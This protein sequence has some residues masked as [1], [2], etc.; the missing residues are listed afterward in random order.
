MMSWGTRH[1]EVMSDV[2]RDEAI[3]VPESAQGLRHLS[4]A[5][6]C[7][8]SDPAPAKGDECVFYVIEAEV[9]GQP[10]PMAGPQIAQLVG[11]VFVPLHRAIAEVLR[12]AAGE[13][14]LP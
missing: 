2:I 11:A 1:L 3:A 8:G 14:F 4:K 9:A 6:N 12:P 13:E 10:R 5:T 7:L